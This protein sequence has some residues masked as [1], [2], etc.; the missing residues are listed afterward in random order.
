[1]QPKCVAK[2]M[3]YGRNRRGKCSFSKTHSFAIVKICLHLQVVSTGLIALGQLAQ[4]LL[5]GNP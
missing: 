1:M 3:N 5:L 4:P 2:A